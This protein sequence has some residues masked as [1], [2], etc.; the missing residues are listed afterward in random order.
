SS[1]PKNS[2]KSSLLKLE[3]YF[4]WTLLKEDVDLDEMEEKVN[5]QIEF[6]T[7][8]KVTNYNLLSYLCHLNNS[9]EE[10]LSN[11]HK[12]EEEVKRKH[13]DEIARRSL[14]TW[15]NYAWIYYHME[16][17]KEAEAYVS[18]VKT[19]LR[20]LPSTPQWKAQCPE[21]Y[22]EEGWAC[23]KFGRKYHRRAN[24]C[25][26]NALRQEPNNPEFNAGYAITV[27]RLENPFKRQSLSLAPLKR[28]VEL[29][30]DNTFVT[31][32]L[33]LKLQDL[34][35]TEEGEIYMEEAMKKTPDL[36]YVLRY[37]AKFYRRKGELQKALEILK[38]TLEVTPNSSFF[39]HQL[40]LCYRSELFRLKEATRCPPR[41]QVDKLIQLC[42]FH[43]KT[44]I[45]IKPK[46]FYVHVDLANM[47]IEAKRYE[48]AEEVFQK[49]FQ[50]NILSDADKQQL[51]YYYGTFNHF[52]MRN[53][54]EAIEY[55]TKGLEMKPQSPYFTKCKNALK[56]LL[57]SRIQRGSKDA[58][59]FG[60]LG[61][62]YDL[63]GEKHEAIR[64]YE[65]ALELNPDS[66]EYL[67]AL[68]ELRLSI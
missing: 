22:A 58:T 50:I 41:E 33:A 29:D 57:Q 43:F 9:N 44:V 40:G 34:N 46:F 19:G 52:H 23:L 49:A 37:A 38:K 32:L 6:F 26:A 24:D 45:E 7:K 8:S 4:T 30:P 47:Y 67:S 36:P 54:S 35:Q 42:I 10:A 3:C 53:E 39:H 25:F 31:V 28:A 60:T 2:L 12:A 51:Y 48:E 65:Q 56:S 15:G 1:V 17:Y 68:C 63:T 13:P 21:I 14:V 62:V 59:D 55:Y 11:L 18:K 64:C 61:F 16:R 5:H 66:E 20:N 27:Y